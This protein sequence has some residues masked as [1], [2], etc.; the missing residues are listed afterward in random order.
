[1]QVGLPHPAYQPFTIL[2]RRPPCGEGAVYNVGQ[3]FLLRR[4]NSVGFNL[5]ATQLPG[6][7]TTFAGFMKKFSL[8]LA[9][10]G[11]SA[12]AT[13]AQKLRVSIDTAKYGVLYKN[14]PSNRNITIYNDAPFPI[15][16]IRLKTT[17][18]DF[19]VSDT[20]I[21]TIQAYASK[22]VTVTFKPRHNVE[23]HE[24]L[25]VIT[26]SAYG[27]KN[28]H[29]T[30]SGYYSQSLY[31]PT[32]NKWEGDLLA[33]LKIISSKN[34]QT[35][36]YTAVRDRMYDQ[37]DNFGGDITCVYTGRVATFNTRAGAVDNNFTA[38][39][40][41]P[42]SKF[43]SVDPMQSD[44]HHLFP[45]DGPA[46]TR[47]S[48]DP[49]GIVTSPV[50]MEG[51]SL[52]DNSY[53]EPRDYHKGTAARAMFYMVTR[54]QDFTG[55]FAPQEDL[56]REWALKFLPDSKD[57]LRHEKAAQVQGNRNPFTDH[58]EF[59]ERISNFAGPA[60]ALVK[61][62][63][64]TYT[65]PVHLGYVA[66][67]DTVNHTVIAYNNGTDVLNVTLTAVNPKP[68]PN[69]TTTVT[70]FILQPGQ[71]YRIPFRF[72][73]KNPGANFT[74]SF[75][76][77]V[78]GLNSTII[79]FN[80]N[81]SGLSAGEAVKN[82]VTLYPNPATTTVSIASSRALKLPCSVNFYDV[83]GRLVH[84]TV[85][86]ESFTD[87]NIASLPAGCYFVQT[88]DGALSSVAKFVKY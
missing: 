6:A 86:N 7:C 77:Q 41:F 58:P 29:L 70:G 59:I 42:Q 4:N 43:G 85:L 63:L 74:D 53:F 50:W 32:Y 71:A 25:L 16:G 51:G 80:A 40:T 54:Y 3:S 84:S 1:M 56:L 48:N 5:A 64:L 8:L 73:G 52:S 23:Y 13:H 2:Q 67:N 20:L 37:V 15:T 18:R 61:N 45:A 28:V 65:G 60:S 46:N 44:I 17:D 27:S 55:F 31:D 38:E 75:N 21:D 88:N 19:T 82:T 78:Q 79:A 14:V 30:G 76:L 62:M 9:L 36:G 87:I 39:H 66:S 49:F 68:Q 33:E 34:A 12:L 83:T 72:I 11:I 81:V 69:V 22:L 10:V 57:S 35:L 24:E 47:R 26:G